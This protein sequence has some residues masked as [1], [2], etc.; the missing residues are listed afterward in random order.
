MSHDGKSSP[1]PGL[2]ARIERLIEKA[3]IART[4]GHPREAL[5][6]LEGARQLA[7]GAPPRRQLLV[8]ELRERAHS[9]T[10][11]GD[12]RAAHQALAMSLE[13]AGDQPA[14]TDGIRADLAMLELMADE[15]DAADASVASIRGRERRD[16]LIARARLELFHGSTNRAER[17]LQAAEQAP[18]GIDEL[19]PPS[20][21]LRSL[22]QLWD[23]RPEQAR[24]LMDGVMV[25]GNPYWELVRLLTMR[26]LWVESGDA[27]YLQLSLGIAE[28]LRFE[29]RPRVLPGLLPAA[30]SQ[31]AVLLSLTGQTF[32]AVQAADEA[33]DK[34]G[35]LTLPE[36]PRAAIL[37]DLGVVYRDA[38]NDERWNAVV[39]LWE[40]APRGMWPERM[41][42]VTG[43]RARGAVETLQSAHETPTEAAAHDLTEVALAVA[44][45]NDH[46]ERVLLSELVSVGHGVGARW[47]DAEGRT[48]ATVGI[49]AQASRAFALNTQRTQ[50]EELSD[51]PAE[52]DTG[53]KGG[54]LVL[55]GDH[56]LSLPWT[57]TMVARLVEM[58]RRV[59]H[60]RTAHRKLVAALE[61][62]RAQRGEAIDA[63]ERVRRGPSARLAGGAFPSVAGR[64]KALATVLDRLGHLGRTSLPILVEGEPGSGRRHLARALAAFLSGEPEGCVQLDLALVPKETMVSTLGRL[65]VEAG[66][67]PCVIAGV[68]HLTAQA[69]SWL[70]PRLAVSGRGPRLLLT[71]DDSA[72]GAM[73]ARLRET[74]EASRVRVPRLDERLGDLP[75][76]IDALVTQMGARPE[77]VGVGARSV[78]ARRLWPGHVAELRH[79]LAQGLVRAGAK[80]IT[81]ELLVPQKNAP[82]ANL[83]EGVD[84]GYHAAIKSFRERLLIHALETTGGNRTQ[85]AKLLDVQRTYFMRLIRDL[86]TPTA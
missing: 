38:G 16:T 63:L 40:G 80:T 75:D 3:R 39:E 55:F 83:S 6:V 69:A 24:L 15:I 45:A 13:A 54:V 34:L 19:A 10:G 50:D 57:N 33:V 18:G 71:A 49:E 76:I 5:N 84:L 28:Q 64:S 43:P 4:S 32:L 73:L 67:T 35:T 11:L 29:T 30:L 70:L 79:A 9:Y 86:D 81:P 31:H 8:A 74:L 68:E 22:V 61:L 27:R 72:D 20:T 53:D 60:K 21:A 85:A 17:S 65:L 46:W 41:L 51:G 23:G 36:W 58:A 62:S 37:Q 7:A 77:Q 47:L 48:V 59:R 12:Y 42:R 26:A 52:D 2:P 44:E 25:P 1:P 82:V 66:Q 14:R 78:L 56:A